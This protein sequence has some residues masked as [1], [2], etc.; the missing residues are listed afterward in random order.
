MME[1]EFLSLARVIEIHSDQIER[2]GGQVGVR[3]MR[4][5]QSAIAMPKASF[6]GEWLHTD[7]YEMA[8]VYAFHISQN[9]PFNDGNKRTGLVCALLF[10]R[11]NGV[12]IEDPERIL[13]RAMMDIAT[14]TLDKLGLAEI[15]R[16]L[17]EQE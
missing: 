3:D 12:P 1:P 5:L 2:Y 8:A 16:S 14:G 4:L 11:L 17:A 15:F 7:I 9:H 13:Y 6:G 10:L